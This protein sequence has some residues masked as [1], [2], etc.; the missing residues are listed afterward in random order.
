MNLTLR[1]IPQ[2]LPDLACELG[3][4][5]RRMASI[6]KNSA[7][8]EDF[9]LTRI[10][11]SNLRFSVVA[12]ERKFTPRMNSRLRN[13]SVLFWTATQFPKMNRCELIKARIY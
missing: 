3:A 4:T 1:G 13:Q 2:V 7:K 8:N 10:S 5:I 9:G 12:R 6:A 11:I